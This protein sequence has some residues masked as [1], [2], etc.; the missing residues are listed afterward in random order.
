M[1]IQFSKYRDVKRD[2]VLKDRLTKRCTNEEWKAI[3]A[4]LNKIVVSADELEPADQ[5]HITLS[6]PKTWGSWAKILEGASSASSS[7]SAKQSQPQQK[8]ASKPTTQDESF[9]TC[10]FDIF[11]K[12][13]TTHD[14]EPTVA[15]ATAMNCKTFPTEQ[16][17]ATPC[18][19]NTAQPSYNSPERCK[20]KLLENTPNDVESSP[21]SFTEAEQ[22]SMEALLKKPLVRRPKTKTKAKASCMKKQASKSPKSSNTSKTV[23]KI[24][25]STLKKRAVSAAYHKALKTTL[26]QNG[27][28]LEAAKASARE[29][30]K[31]AAASFDSK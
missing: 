12:I 29:A 20:W 25:S 23:S 17:D 16:L 18:S 15:T 22:T 30:Y 8:I 2:L 14:D 1:R 31:L 27:G 24:S 10:K 9:I 21:E 19:A 28:D 7:S 26:Q 4:V 3:D 6:P 11:K 13:T 5:K